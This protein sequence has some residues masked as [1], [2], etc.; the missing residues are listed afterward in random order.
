MELS[1]NSYND[2]LQMPVDDLKNYID[3]KIKFDK[4]RQKARSEAIK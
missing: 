3:W 1:G 2:V 4:E